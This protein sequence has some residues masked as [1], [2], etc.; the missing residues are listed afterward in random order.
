M[1]A[2]T[3][4]AGL[5]TL[6][7]AGQLVP[8]VAKARRL[9][10]TE[11]LSPSWAMMGITIN[12]GWVAYRWSQELW[13]GL[14]SPTIACVLYASVLWLIASSW[15]GQ[16]RGWVLG[17]LVAVSLTLAAGFGNWGLVGGLLGIWS[18]LQVGPAVWAAYR[19]PGP[20]GIAIWVWIIGAIQA[21]LWAYYGWA[22]ED[23][24]L[25]AYGVVVVIGSLAILVRYRMTR[26]IDG[27]VVPRHSPMA[28][29]QRPRC[30][31]G[32][33]LRCGNRCCLAT[34]C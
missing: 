11:G 4:S 7:S 16:W 6:L 29:S 27:S 30:H 2:T 22:N 13:I 1:D 3:I 32:P 26:R 20:H 33:A 34:P 5:A 19:S 14:L 28:P 24:A 31:V 23:A 17:S 8:Q 10:S 18:G 9:R 25:L 12:A 21:S 15:R